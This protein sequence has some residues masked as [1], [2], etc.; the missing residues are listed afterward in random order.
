MGWWRLLRGRR[1]KRG[2]PWAELNDLL[3]LSPSQFEEAVGA[4]FRE[5][6]F[7]RVKRVGGSG[8]LSV[9]LTCR[10]SGTAKCPRQE[11]NLRARFRRTRLRSPGF[12]RIRTFW[13]QTGRFVAASAA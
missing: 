9:D 6:G 10:D 12:S 7:R 13:P 11:S 5:L 3:A 4:I 2:L 1:V 8:D